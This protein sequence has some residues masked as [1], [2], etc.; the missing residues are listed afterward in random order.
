MLAVLVRSPRWVLFCP[1]A[2]LVSIAGQDLHDSS[3]CGATHVAQTPVPG[4]HIAMLQRSATSPRHAPD[5]KAVRTKDQVPPSTVVEKLALLEDTKPK[6][7]MSAKRKIAMDQSHTNSVSV[8][9]GGRGTK[10]DKVKKQLAARHEQ[11]ATKTIAE[12]KRKK[13]A[14][15]ESSLWSSWLFPASVVVPFLFLVY[16]NPVGGTS[17][18]D[19][20]MKEVKDAEEE[21]YLDKRSLGTAC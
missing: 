11:H 19:R 14:Q 4:R 20:K 15:K 6:V 21:G 13:H 12:N 1:V 17:A 10:A 3:A 18:L 8:K 2:T 16:G 5:Q 7:S 9:G